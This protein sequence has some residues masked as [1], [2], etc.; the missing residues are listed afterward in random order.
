MPPTRRRVLGLAVAG[1]A[2]LAGC[3]Q[4]ESADSDTTATPPSSAQAGT[5]ASATTAEASGPPT[6]D[7][8]YHLGW[9]VQT[10]RDNVVSGG[11]RKDGI[12]SIDEPQFASPDDV[13]HEPGDPV[14]GV[15]RD[16][17]A[18]AY[19]QRILV[20]HEIVNDTVGGD[21]VSV[22]YCPLTGT[23]Q[24]FERG[25]TT[26]GVSGNLVNSNLVMYDRATDSRWP[27]IL[28]TA[29]SGD[30]E[31]ESLQEF[32]VV[33]TTWA[34]WRNAHPDTAILTEDTGYVRRYDRD[35]YGTYNP[36]S[37]YYENRN[38]LFSPL[39]EDERGHPKDVVV[40]AR[41]DAEAVAFVKST[42][43]EERVLQVSGEQATFVAVSDPTYST[44]Y[45]YENPDGVSVEPNGEQY[46]VD[47]ESYAPDALPLERVRAFDA[48]WFAWTGLYPESTY[49][50]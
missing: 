47:G 16:G 49:V 41:T 1:L 23:A 37:R 28:S 2:S 34:A 33:W 9:D 24:G 19:P 36:K 21:P 14:F 10:L 18:K 4:L 45:I 39:Q 17:E 27:Q 42:L 11:V 46:A 29:V 44:A 7:V 22:T 6:A 43:L 13:Q 40:G 48:M 30:L 31:G 26:F 32:R 5:A 8:Q 3:A 12:P 50:G 15:V 38:L 20:H 35:P 25:E